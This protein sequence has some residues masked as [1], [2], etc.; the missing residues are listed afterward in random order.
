M[1]RQLKKG[2]KVQWDTPQGKTAGT[3]KKKLTKPTQIKG[4]KAAA[5]QEN[6]EYLVE[7]DKSGKQAIHKPDEL[8]PVSQNKADRIE[9]TRNPKGRSH[10]RRSSSGKR[11]K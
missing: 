2:S 6:P 4:H 8:Q 10:S 5:S 11:K 7:S 9:S 3:V 1:A